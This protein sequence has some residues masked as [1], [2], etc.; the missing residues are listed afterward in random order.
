MRMQENMPSQMQELICINVDKVYD[1]IVK[2]LSFE[3]SPTNPVSFPGVAVDTDLNGA[4]VK[5]KVEPTAFEPI[6]I[7]HRENRTFTVEG[8]SVCLQ[9]LT[10]QKN[11]TL[12]IYV[13][14]P[15]G[16]VHTSA[17]IPVSRCEQV[18]M[19]APKGTDVSVTYTNLDCFVCST[20]TLTAGADSI[21]FNNLSISVTVCQSIQSTFPVTVEFL[22][23]FCEPR[24]EL[25]FACPPASR[26][27]QCSVIYP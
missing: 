3:I 10:I 12:T 1:W 22:A 18:V 21:T 6:L 23:D 9:Q 24:A 7:K 17:E 5:C 4:T 25:P 26:P 14:L 20:G 2:D 11:F 15:S 27:N 19:C 8:K 16:I 13:K